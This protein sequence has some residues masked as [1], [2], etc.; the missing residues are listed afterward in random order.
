MDMTAPDLNATPRP[1]LMLPPWD[2]SHA[3]GEARRGGSEAGESEAG[4]SEAGESEAGESEAGESEAGRARREGE[5]RTIN[6]Q[7]T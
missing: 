6:C 1:L 3:W 4:E 2:G 7:L 5:G